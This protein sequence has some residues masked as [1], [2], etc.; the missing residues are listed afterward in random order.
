[1]NKQQWQQLIKNLGWWGAY[2]KYLSSKD[3]KRK[4]EE[5]LRRDDNKCRTCKNEEN[6]PLEVHHSKGHGSIP[7][8]T[9]DE[10]ITL[11]K[12]CHLAITNN[13]RQRRYQDRQIKPTTLGKVPERNLLN[14]DMAKSKLQIKQRITNNPSQWRTS[15][16]AK[17]DSEGTEEN[18]GQAKQDR[19]RLNGIG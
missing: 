8:E 12:S 1:M 15:K 10:L 3:W 4:R 9:I 19:S 16:S 13:D 18:I 14:Y 2:A 7:N 6:Y 11:C 17:P 5:V